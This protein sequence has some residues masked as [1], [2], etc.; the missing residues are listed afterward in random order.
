VAVVVAAVGPAAIGALRA[1]LP[2]DTVD[3]TATM[4]AK[5]AAHPGRE[6][7]VLWLTYLAALTLPLGALIVGRVAIRDRPVLGAL[8][9]TLAWAGFTSLFVS[10]TIGDYVMASADGRLPAAT[11][12]AMVDA[13]AT[14]PPVL[15]ASVVFVV[16]HIVGGLL[17]AAALWR[18]VPRWATLA[19]GLSMPLHFVFALL[20]PSG[21]L[22]AV[23]WALT[24]LGLAAAAG[25]GHESAPPPD[26][27]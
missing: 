3:D 2:Y 4:M 11:T 21:A 15:L 14:Q 18:V 10:V 17:L 8:G 5:V 1:V 12:A 13:V 19:L 25:T 22:D 23:A 24:G 16:G 6:T 26:A 27:R 9:A 7:A 20:I